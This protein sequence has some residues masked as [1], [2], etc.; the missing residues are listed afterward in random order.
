MAFHQHLVF[1]KPF[2]ATFIGRYGGSAGG[3]CYLVEEAI[4]LAFQ[5]PYTLAQGCAALADV[6]SPELPCMHE[7][8][9]HQS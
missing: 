5:L 3:I 6:L 1:L 8:V 2:D 4:D 9:S 7:H